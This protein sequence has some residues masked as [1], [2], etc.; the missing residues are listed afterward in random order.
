[1]LRDCGAVG[2]EDVGEQARVLGG[3]DAPAR[4]CRYRSAANKVNSS[5]LMPISTGTR[6]ARPSADAATGSVRQQRCPGDRTESASESPMKVVPGRTVK[7]ARRQRT[8]TAPRL[9]GSRQPA[10]TRVIHAAALRRSRRVGLR[11]T[12][13]ALDDRRAE[14]PR[15]PGRH[16]VIAHRHAARGFA[17]DRHLVAGR[18]RNRRCCRAPSAARPAG[19]PARSCRRRP[20][21]PRD[22]WARKPSA[23]SR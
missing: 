13:R 12:G 3:P 15:R 18:R 5:W 1:M 21:A 9:A 11:L 22:G 7:L 23:P 14:Q 20:A 4:I 6:A 2:A 19:R 17:G 10:D 8:Q 16:Q